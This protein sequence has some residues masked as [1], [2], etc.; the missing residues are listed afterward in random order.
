M[1]A[2]IH[3][4]DPRDVGVQIQFRCPFWYRAQLMDMA[5]ERGLT[6]S[7]FVVTTIESAIPPVK[8]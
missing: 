4:K 1:R 3:P 6:L 8:R 7:E 2:P 5:R